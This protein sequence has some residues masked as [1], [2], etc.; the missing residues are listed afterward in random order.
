[1]GIKGED[2]QAKGISN[3][4]NKITAENLQNLKEELSNQIQEASRTP[5]R[6]DK[7]GISPWHIITETTSTETRERLLKTIREKKQIT[8]KGKPIKITQTS[9]KKS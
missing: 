1:M 4:F 2:E 7:N 3:I 8:C 5:N 6:L 9:Q